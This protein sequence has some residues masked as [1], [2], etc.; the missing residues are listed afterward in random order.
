VIS[1]LLVDDAEESATTSAVMTSVPVSV[2]N[3]NVSVVVADVP[4]PMMME[5]GSVEV[6]VS[7]V[8]VAADA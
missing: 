2:L 1:T 6:E 7:K 5:D 8:V 4:G 3:V